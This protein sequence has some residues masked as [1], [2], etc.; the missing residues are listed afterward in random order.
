MGQ[1]LQP[2]MS[3]QSDG[4]V[5]LELLQSQITRFV[6]AHTHEVTAKDA[7]L[8]DA[9]AELAA[10][11]AELADALALIKSMKDEQSSE[12]KAAASRK[13]T[14]EREHLHKT[15]NT[16]HTV[17]NTLHT[18]KKEKQELECTVAKRSADLLERSAELLEATHGFGIDAHRSI[19]SANAKAQNAQLAGECSICMESGGNH[20]EYCI[21]FSSINNV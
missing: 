9:R 5:L 18:V 10:K 19:E 3:Q 7:E 6:I 16:L 8:A 17:N 2:P 11:D 13:R 14:R 20:T 1:T 12:A 15:N 4:R 21:T